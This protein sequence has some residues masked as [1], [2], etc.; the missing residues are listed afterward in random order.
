MKANKKVVFLLLCLT[1]FVSFILYFLWGMGAKSSADSSFEYRLEIPSGSGIRSVSKKLKENGVIRSSLVF[2]AAARTSLFKTLDS[3]FMLKSGV[4]TLSSSMSVADIVTLLNSGKQEYIKTVIQEGLTKGQI[5]RTL[6]SL[7]VCSAEDFLS[8]VSDRSLLD[9][10][11]LPEYVTDLEGFLFPD[12]Y[13]FAPG[14]SG[15][16][17]AAIMVDNF[18]SHMEQIPGNENLEF[19]DFYRKLILASIV[20]K[21]FLLNSEAP[22][23]A[24]VF[25]NR[26]KINMGLESCA[27]VNYILE[28]IQGHEHKPVLSK[29]DIAIDNP[30]NTYKWAGLSM[31]PGPI[32]NPGDVALKAAF[33]PPRTGYLFFVSKEDGS[34]GHVFSKTLDEHNLAKYN[35]K[36]SRARAASK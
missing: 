32:S 17:V 2:Y 21:E 28:E 22:L 29:D 7:S 23:V 1:L 36:R 18:Y 5:A 34:G 33:N 27:T 25:A 11:N 19:D 12:T 6:E 26:I 30:Y 10:R 3:P 31:I 13:F 20:E 14:M 8:A 9:A 35:M 15:S 16:D 24:S 4:Y